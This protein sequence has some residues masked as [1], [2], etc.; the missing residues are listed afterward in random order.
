M[1]KVFFDSNNQAIFNLRKTNMT[2]IFKK[3]AKLLTSLEEAKTNL[4]NLG[5]H[6]KAY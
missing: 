2:P 6:V 4:K 3:N 5:G 1:A